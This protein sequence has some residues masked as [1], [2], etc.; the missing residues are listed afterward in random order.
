MSQAERE[1]ALVAGY[2]ADAATYGDEEYPGDL[3]PGM[4]GPGAAPVPAR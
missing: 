3:Q 1:A 2:G 4:G